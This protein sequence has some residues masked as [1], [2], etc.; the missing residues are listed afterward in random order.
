MIPSF[1]ELTFR[2][3]SRDG[4]GRMGIVTRYHW[5]ALRPDGEILTGG[6]RTRKECETDARD[7]LRLA[8]RMA[9]E[10]A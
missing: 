4:Y 8:D 9:K 2:R 6:Q 1:D 7:V 10:Q 5:Q 3:V